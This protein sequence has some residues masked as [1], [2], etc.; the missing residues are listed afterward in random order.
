HNFLNI[1]SSKSATGCNGSKFAHGRLRKSARS[2]AR[3]RWR[4]DRAA[5]K[6]TRQIFNE[7]R[8]QNGGSAEFNHCAE[9]EMTKSDWL[10]PNHLARGKLTM[11]CG[12]S[13][14]GKSQISISLTAALTN[15]AEWPDGN[16]A[17]SGSVIILSAEDATN[18][19]IVPRLTAAGADLNRVYVLKCVRVEG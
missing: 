12:D 1:N 15:A 8:K 19:T 2:L 6:S 4:M 5:F 10:W 13:T 17:P 9:I 11:L 14:L 3:G 16:R 18:D 7:R